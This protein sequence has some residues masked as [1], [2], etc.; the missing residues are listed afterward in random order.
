MLGMCKVYHYI[1]LAKVALDNNYWSLLMR[2]FN[3]SHKS[4]NLLD[5]M[6]LCVSI[7]GRHPPLSMGNLCMWTFGLL[8]KFIRSIRDLKQCQWCR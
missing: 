2:A 3:L 5:C 4:M 8:S 6:A 7:F 1:K